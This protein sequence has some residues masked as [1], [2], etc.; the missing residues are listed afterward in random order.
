[1]VAF[2]IL[3]LAP[4]MIFQI[5]LN[6]SSTEELEA[7]TP[8]IEKGAKVVYF[9]KELKNRITNKGIINVN[10]VGT[11]QKEYEA[12][13][14]IFHMMRYRTVK[15]RDTTPPILTLSGNQSVTICPTKTYREEGYEAFDALDGNITNQVKRTVSKNNINYEVKDKAGNVQK[16]SRH[17]IKKD[18]EKPVIILNN[19]MD[20][21]VP[22]NMEYVESGY[23]AF[24]AC[25]SDISNTV[26][27]S[28]SVDTS[29]PGV[30]EKIYTATDSSG[31]QTS[32]KRT[33]YV[34]KDMKTIYLTFDDGPSSMTP[35][36]L[37]IL[38]KENVKATFF[39]IN[40]G[41]GYDNTIRRASQEGHTI[42]LHSDSHNYQKI[43]QTVN[44]YFD[45]LYQIQRKVKGITGINSTVIRFP[46]GSSNTVSRNYQKGL[47]TTLSKKVEEKGFQYFDWNVGSEDTKKIGSNA[48]AK[49][50]IESLTKKENIVLMHD[51]ENNIQT[52]N[53]LKEIIDYGKSHGYQFS[54]ITAATPP[55]HHPINN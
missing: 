3:I 45:D 29:T 23:V 21:T 55:V 31:N 4:T 52:V 46:G 41:T 53:A 35:L 51:Y 54:S 9:G 26:K 34:V 33:V 36:I 47:M 43:Y 20:I 18:V 19:G 27:I 11:Y 14:G 6:G 12:S 16:I 28:G 17:I 42:G 8:Y 50:V 32:V 49:N 37:D 39:V 22:V 38:K 7:K 2:L 5:I 48:I 15:V 40:H 44:T 10:E 13:Y 1:M 24:D 25:D 30:Y